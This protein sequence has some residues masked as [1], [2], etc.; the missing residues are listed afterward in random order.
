M[1]A[2]DFKT[3][4]NKLLT[5]EVVAYLTQIHEYKGQQNLFIEAKADALSNLLEVAKIQSTEASNRIEGIITTDD[6]LKKIVREKTMPQTRSEKEIAGYRDVLATI[7]ESH[8]YIPPKPAVILQLHRDLYKFSGKSI[9]GSFKN[10]D[11]VI[12]EKLPDGR[13]IVRFEPVS[14]WETP[15]AVS[16]LCDAFRTAM[17]DTELDPLLLISMFIVDFLNIA[18]FDNSTERMSRLLLALLLY[19]SGYE[20]EQ[21]S[22][23]DAILLNTKVS[24]DTSL[25]RSS[26]NWAASTNDYAPFTAYLLSTLV[27]AYKNFDEIATQLTAKG[28]SKPDRVREIIKLH[29]GEITKSEILKQCPDISQITVQRALADLLNNKQITKIGGGRYT[30]Y[31]WNGEN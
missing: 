31:I 29:Q 8:D 25:Q 3:E 20:V 15:G 10:S 18:P 22:S 27:T 7:H 19:R 23:I 12:A 4:Y 17:Q 13:K 30:S 26:H 28:L 14:A 6:R 5:P 2:F 16:A 1:R 21:Y 11:N 9:G 24:Y